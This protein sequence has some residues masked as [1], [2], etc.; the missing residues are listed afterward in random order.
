MT[1]AIII[2]TCLHKPEALSVEEL[3]QWYEEY[4]A[5]ITHTLVPESTIVRE[6]HDD[7][8]NEVT[9]EACIL[10]LQQGVCVRDGFCK[11]CQDLFDDWPDLGDPETTGTHHSTDRYCIGTGADWKH[12]V[13]RDCHTLVLEASSRLGCKMCAFLLQAMKD[14]ELLYTFRRIEARLKYLGAKDTASLSIQNWG[15][16]SSQLLW[17]NFPGK[18]NDH[19]N[20]GIASYIKFYSNALDPSGEYCADRIYKFLTQ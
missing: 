5:A 4:T 8:L 10:E 16:N 17:V 18:I 2:N 20:E 7:E 1:S 19:C 11:D 13:A 6:V 9:I 14:C 3:R 15:E 12:T